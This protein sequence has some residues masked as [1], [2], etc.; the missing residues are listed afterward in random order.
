MQRECKAKGFHLE[1]A[2]AICAHLATCGHYFQELH[3]IQI[4]PIFSAMSQKS[5]SDITKRVDQF[6]NYHANTRVINGIFCGGY[7]RLDFKNLLQEAAMKAKG[8]VSGL[9]LN[10]VTKWKILAHENCGA[11][12]LENCKR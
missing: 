5:I 7:L 8:A 2:D 3:R 6:E 12:V 11:S 9:C 1:N 10:C 4:W